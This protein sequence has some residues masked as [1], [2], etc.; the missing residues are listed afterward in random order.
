LRI[1]YVLVIIFSLAVSTG[2]EAAQ[3][4]LAWDPNPEPSIS[5][6]KVYFGKAS[7]HYSSVIDVGN[8]AACLITGLDA[9][10]T[11]FFACTDYNS[12]GIESSFSNEIVYTVPVANPAPS[13]SPA[14]SPASSTSSSSGGGGGCFIATA[15]YGSYLAPE[16]MALRE[17]RDRYLLTHGPG[18]AFVDGYYRIS[19]PVATFIAEHEALKTAVRWGLTPVVYGAK[20]PIAL[21]VMIIL[22]PAVVILRRSTKCR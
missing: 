4:T 17:F 9:G 10:V 14:S 5:G 2:L 6:Y 1:S 11:Y 13:P 21:L 18:Q 3:V 8:H 7:G 19:P 16:V 20:Y 12:T 15:A 22:I